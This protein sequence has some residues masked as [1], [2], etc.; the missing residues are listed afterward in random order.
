M[1]TS[2]RCGEHNAQLC[3][4]FCPW[5]ECGLKAPGDS[6]QVSTR[7]GTLTYLRRRGPADT[8]VWKPVRA[9]GYCK[10]CHGLR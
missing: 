1:L 7:F 6:L 2:E 4:G 10:P 5:P 8:Y 9:K 3:K